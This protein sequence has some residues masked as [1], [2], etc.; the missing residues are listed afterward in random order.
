M[1]DFM[2]PLSNRSVTKSSHTNSTSTYFQ[3]FLSSWAILASLL[4]FLSAFPVSVSARENV[5]DGTCGSSNGAALTSAPTTKLCATDKASAVGG[6]GPRSWSRARING[7]TNAAYSTLASNANGACG[8]AMAVETPKAPT[9][10]LC[11][12]GIPS[13][14]AGPNSFGWSTSQVGG[15]WT[16]SCAGSGSGTTA[17]CLAS[18]GMP[19]PGAPLDVNGNVGKT[20]YTSLPF[21]TNILQDCWGCSAGLEPLQLFAQANANSFF[22]NGSGQ[23][24]ASRN[25]VATIEASGAVPFGGAQR[26]EDT[27]V[28]AFP[29][30][31]VNE[32]SDVETDRVNFNAPNQPEFEA[33]RDWIDNNP[34]YWDTASDAGTVPVYM[35]SWGSSIGDGASRGGQWGFIS[36]L[37]PLNVADCPPGMTSCT[38]GDFM[39]IAGASPRP[40]MVATPS[41]Y[42]IF[43][44]VFRMEVRASTVL[45]HA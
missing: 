43:R 18:A 39:R 7:G 32:P 2:T 36:P 10:G 5:V 17:S 8:V 25:A 12:S 14:V 20:S 28:A 35:R 16:W 29:V 34:Q 11:T 40:W 41:G 30:R 45:I 37:T 21:A 38:W 31:F 1:G 9:S 24:G 27:W 19:G 44:T 33:W 22:W 26:W 3:N 15:V 23:L 6:T 13:T 4:G 42:R